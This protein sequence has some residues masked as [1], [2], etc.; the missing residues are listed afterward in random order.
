[1]EFWWWIE[2][3]YVTGIVMILIGGLIGLVCDWNK[4]SLCIISILAIPGI[5]ASVSVFIWVI[6]WT[7]FQT[8][9]PYFG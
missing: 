4:A 8:W 3:L 2:P 6:T 1:M 5:V 9:S 7:L